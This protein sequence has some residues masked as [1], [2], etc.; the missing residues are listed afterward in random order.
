MR[1]Q[2]PEP[3]RVTKH[4]KSTLGSLVESLS[5]L[6]EEMPQYADYQL[7]T[8]HGP[9]FHV[10]RSCDVIL[11]STEDEQEFGVLITF[12]PAPEHEQLPGPVH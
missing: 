12:H 7:I 4:G 2:M 8:E 10:V 1:D 5:G 3:I 11:M 9:H 6:L